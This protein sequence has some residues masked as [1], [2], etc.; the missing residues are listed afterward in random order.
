MEIEANQK[1]VDYA[2]NHEAKSWK[3]WG[4]YFIA[5]IVPIIGSLMVL[6][7]MMVY[8][9]DEIVLP[10]MPD[11]IANA[12]PFFILGILVDLFVCWRKGTIN[13]FRLNDSISS[14][15]MGAFQQLIGSTVKGL[16]VFPYAY[17]HYHFRIIDV[18]DTWLNWC[19]MFIAVEYGYY[20]F[21]RFSHEWN[22]MW[23]GHVVH[24]TSEE[25]NLTTALRQG[26]LS[27]FFSW[28][29]YLPAAF[30]FPVGLYNFHNQWNTLY[31]FWIHTQNIRKM[32]AAF[33]YIFNTPSHHRVHH[34]RNIKYIDKNFGGTLIIFDRIFKT[35]EPEVDPPLYGISHGLGSWNPFYLQFHHLLEMKE[36]CDKIPG[37]WNKI[38]LLLDVGPAFLWKINNYELIM[39]RE[40]M[41]ERKNKQATKKAT[42]N[43]SNNINNGIHNESQPN[44]PSDSKPK[45]VK[46]KV[47]R[48]KR[49][50][51]AKYDANPK[52][53][54][55]TIYATI[56]FILCIVQLAIYLQ[57]AKYSA[58][59]DKLLAVSVLLFQLYT[60]AGIFDQIEN[61]KVLELLR[62]V[63]HMFLMVYTFGI[64]AYITVT[65][66]IVSVLSCSYLI[67]FERGEATIK[68]D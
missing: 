37:N 11:Y 66:I 25:Y 64:S 13:E 10:N 60:V 59:G 9:Y 53:I 18:Y 20:W 48:R 51:R 26:S 63:I 8:G 44:S 35:F 14:I 52:T 40:R 29:F 24:H 23:A 27:Q 65:S 43:G 17:V 57:I 41:K 3:K 22:L 49:K 31:Q 67:F 56:Q 2:V 61:I 34:G 7:L 30:V 4:L 12:V 45:T 39:K 68:E 19:I 6:L 33:E 21:H 62:N 28:M 47:V 58:F 32:P 55:L 46:K 38:R 16:S 15:S 5:G 54:G 50:K 36:V 1:A 42:T